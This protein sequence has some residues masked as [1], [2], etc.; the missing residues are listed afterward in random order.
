MLLVLSSLTRHSS[1]PMVIPRW[2]SLHPDFTE[3]LLIET[4]NR[5]NKPMSRQL[6]AK[7]RISFDVTG[8]N[9]TYFN[10]T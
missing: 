3:K 7:S 8:M 9:C 2:G 1:S 10:D 5:K 6:K 4:L